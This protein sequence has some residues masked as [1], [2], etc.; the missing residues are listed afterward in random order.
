[1]LHVRICTALMVI[2]SCATSSP[3]QWI[4][5]TGGPDVVVGTWPVG[6]GLAGTA[7]V[8]ASNFVNGNSATP[9]VAL[10]PTQIGSL[11]SDFFAAGFTTNSGG[12]VPSLATNYN[13]AGDR[14]HVV[15]DFSGTVG[16]PTPGVLPAGTVVVVGDFDIDENYRGARATTAL[17]AQITSGWL[18]GPNGFFDATDPMIPQGS[19]V[20][21]PV[22]AGPAGG[23]YDMFGVSYN[24]DIGMWLFRTTQ[25]V[26]TISVD[27]EKDVGGNGLVNGGAG[28]AF[29]SPAVPEPGSVAMVVGGV[30]MLAGLRRHVVKTRGLI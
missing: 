12:T 3:A 14:Y 18:S 4:E 8:T 15:F 6:S 27:M 26:R 30:L 10:V 5:F 20:P 7:S 21:N 11:S 1:M 9:H 13:D 17:G 25:D 24:F 23:V 22:L 19:L 2:G 29:Y 16:G 28:F